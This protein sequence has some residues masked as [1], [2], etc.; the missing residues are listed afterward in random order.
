MDSGSSTLVN[1][2]DTA[3]LLVAAGRG[4]RAGEGLPK[5]YRSLAG[6]AVISHSIRKMAAALP[7]AAILAVI[8][9]DD[10]ELYTSCMEGVC[11]PRLRAP[12][13]GG[14]TRQ[15]SVRLGLEVL[16]EDLS[17]YKIVIIHDSVRI[18]ASSKLIRS[19]AL[20][21]YE[22]GAVVPACAISDSLLRVRPDGM[23][24]PAE[25]SGLFAVQT[26]Q[27]FRF[28]LILDAHRRAAGEGRGDFTDDASLAEWAGTPVRVIPGEP[29]NFKLTHSQDFAMAE[30]LLLAQ[31]GDIRTG[32]GYDVHAFASGD[33][34]WLGGLRIPH[35]HGLEGHSD[36]DVGLHALTDAI[37]GALADG[38]I[39]SHFPPSDPRW[40]GARSEIFLREAVRRVEERRGMIAH[41]DLTLVC[42][43]PKIGPHRDAIRAEIARIAGLDIGR[44]AVKATTSEKLGFAGRREGIAAN[45]V[46]TIRLPL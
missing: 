25:R 5:Q 22:N 24:E 6:H 34:V 17:D 45:A 19:A 12:T 40:R 43:A 33:H 44:V 23:S 1:F 28:D 29:S 36:A 13:Y 31:L 18:F 37:F 21:A 9:P 10:A 41:L 3:V 7:G 46:A 38:D 39:G 27:A 8:H 35:D 16:H 15:D 32:F 26:P 11:V 2:A 20:A 30:A 42:E 14:A 4:S